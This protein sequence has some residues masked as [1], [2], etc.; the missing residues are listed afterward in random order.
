[1]PGNTL[2]TIDM[3]TAEAVRLFKNSNAFIMNMDTQ[4]DPAF[5]Q[6]GAKIGSSLRIRYPNDY[7]VRSGPAMQIQNTAE[8]YTT[9]TVSD[10]RG[11]DVAFT[12]AERTMAI[13]DYSEIVLAPMIN[14]LA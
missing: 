1:M 10:Q 12:S 2:L 8:K 6:D 14:A 5:A 4:Y 3:I 13:D 11:V 7:V 9:L